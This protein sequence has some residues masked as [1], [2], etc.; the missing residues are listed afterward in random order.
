M[1]LDFLCEPRGESWFASFFC[2]EDRL[3]AFDFLLFF[4]FGDFLEDD[5]YLNSTWLDSHSQD[6]ILDFNS[7]R[8]DS[9]DA[10]FEPNF[11][12]VFF[13]GFSQEALFEHGWFRW[14]YLQPSVSILK[15]LH[16]LLWHIFEIGKSS[17]LLLVS[18]GCNDS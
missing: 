11:G 2:A 7:N 3:D 14:I 16:A 9:R 12:L 18:S 17:Y 6:T 1:Y 4:M 10:T 8:L 5:L 13:L 15:F